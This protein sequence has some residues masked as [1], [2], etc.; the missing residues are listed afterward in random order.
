MAH[1]SLR[2]VL[3]AFA[4]LLCT[5]GCSQPALKD[6]VV[7]VSSVSLSDVS[8]G[9]MTVNTT[10]TIFNP[11]PVGADLKNITFDVWYLDDGEHYLGHG[12]RSG[13]TIR[14]SGNTSVAIPVRIGTIEAAQGIASLI[15]KGSLTVM[16]N[17]SAFVDLRLTTYEKKF[18]RSEEFTAQEFSGLVPPSFNV[19][20]KLGQAEAILNSFAS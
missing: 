17:G 1:G 20:E 19:T 8:P 11:N 12:D 7:S 6:P 15:R 18:S 5:A 16:I 10:L 3:I 2:M 13:I 9:S 14:E 4:I